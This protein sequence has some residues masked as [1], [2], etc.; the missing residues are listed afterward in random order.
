MISSLTFL[1]GSIFNLLKSKKNLF[2]EVFLYKKELEILK[3]QNQKKRLPIQYSD[4]IIFSILNRIGNIKDIL[5]I[6]KP[7]TILLCQKQII[8]RFLTYKS[9]NRAGSSPV[10][11][12][13]K[14]IILNMKNDN[15]N[16]G[17][18]K[19][20]GRVVKMGLILIKRQ[21]EIY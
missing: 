8:K 15:L 13:I 3:R 21:F 6:V 2:L 7:E 4:R 12:E 19:N 20:S 11:K 17:Y 10:K 1:F 14:Q 5:T 18:K 9:K 16:W